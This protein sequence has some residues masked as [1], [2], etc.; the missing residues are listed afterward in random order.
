MTQPTH[1][2]STYMSWRGRTWRR[3]W[4]TSCS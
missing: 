4:W 1:Q 2:R 3:N